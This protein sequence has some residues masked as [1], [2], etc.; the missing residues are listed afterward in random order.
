MKTKN[1]NETFDREQAKLLANLTLQ[2]EKFCQ[3]KESFFATK[4]NLTPVEFKCLRL[5]RDNI[6][7]TTKILAQQ[8]QLT[9]G[10]ITHLLNSLESKNM[11]IRKMDLNDRRSTLISLT[12]KAETFLNDIIEEYITL[13]EEIL[14]HIPTTKRVEVMNNM[15]YFFM[16]FKDWAIEFDDDDKEHKR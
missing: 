6:L 2:M 1:D 12:Q 9:P 11:V 8:M 15:K 4:F 5:I 16:A 14:K 10:R 13:H 3:V 7:V